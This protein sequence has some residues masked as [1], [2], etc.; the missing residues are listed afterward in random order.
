MRIL[1]ALA[2]AATCLTWTVNAAA[3]RPGREYRDAIRQAL[4]EF[5]ASRWEE[6]RVLFQR[7]HD[8][9][10][11][12][13][14]LRGIGMASFEMRD[15]V[16]ADG[17]L[18]AALLSEERP[19]DRRQRS[20]VEEL[21]ARNRQF[22]GRV[23]VVVRPRDAELQVD[24]RP[25]EIDDDGYLL[26]AVGEHTLTATREGYR[27]ATHRLDV[28]GSGEQE[29][30]LVLDE[31]R[32]EEGPATQPVA[33]SSEGVSPLSVVLI[34]SAGA[35]AASAAG[36][37]LWIAGRNDEIARCDAV[38][39]GFMCTNGE[40]LRTERTVAIAFTVTM[41]VGAAVA[42]GLGVYL[43]LAGDEG[44]TEVACAPGPF[45]IGCHASF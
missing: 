37:G 42:A 26:L 32:A 35:L 45:T 27:P 43:I 5:D 4:T 1:F 12:A 18:T 16:A 8:I 7:A 30:R 34:S 17:A 29:V 44:E 2:L 13:R 24:L 25:A 20:A 36:G 19:L 33:P 38:E 23:M 14:T 31:E 39:A 10:P 41:A 21:L 6:A 22:L 40:G 28:E 11:N 15:Y 9:Y 3:Q